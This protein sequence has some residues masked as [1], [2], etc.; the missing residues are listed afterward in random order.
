M[1]NDG[2][3]NIMNLSGGVDLWAKEIDQTMSKYV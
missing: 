1:F 2:F 3:I